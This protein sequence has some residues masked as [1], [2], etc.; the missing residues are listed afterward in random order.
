MSADLAGKNFGS[1]LNQTT[2]WIF[3]ISI[4]PSIYYTC[5]Y[6]YHLTTRA[7]RPVLAMILRTS[8]DFKL[9]F[10]PKLSGLVV[11]ASLLCESKEGFSTS[12]DIHTHTCA[13]TCR[14]TKNEIMSHY[15]VLL[16]V[17]AA[18]FAGRKK[19][20]SRIQIRTPTQ[21]STM[22]KKKIEISIFCVSGRTCYRLDTR[23]TRFCMCTLIQTKKKA[24]LLVFF[25]FSSAKNEIH[26][27]TCIYVCTRFVILHAYEMKQIQYI[28]IHIHTCTYV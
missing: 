25:F 12:A 26:A 10:E 13:R 5:L 17:R 20:S 6:L 15:F 11:R 27:Y 1:E 14:P 18:F 16:M 24:T 2:V 23:Y 3:Q 22:P 9:N 8:A 19:G 28:R 4:Y 7:T 21:A